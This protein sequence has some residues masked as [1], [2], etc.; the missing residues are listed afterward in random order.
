MPA[1][2]APAF[3]LESL[4]SALPK[5]F[6]QAQS[7]AANH[8]KNFVA[9]C[10]LQSDAAKL[11][12][13]VQ[14]GRSIKLSGERVF[15]EV[16]L[17]MLTRVLP[18]KKGTSVA[19]RIVK[20]TSGYAR[21]ITEKNAEERKKEEADD[22]DDTP[23]SRFLSRIINFLLK[24]CVAKDKVVRFRVVQ[25]I[26]DMI[27]HLGE[28][29]E[30][31]Y[32]SLRSSL[33]ERL[34]DKEAMV[35]VHAVVALSKLSFSEEPS[36]LEEGESSILDTLIDTMTYDTSPDVR[37]A[38]LL[39][40]R[41]VP[42]TLSA[43]LARTRD[44][45]P[46]IRRLV[47]SA[48]L[49]DKCTEGDGERMG[50]T[51]PR[52][53]TIAQ[54]ELIVRNGLGDRE[55]AVRAAA[56]RLLGTWVDVAR[57]APDEAKEEGEKEQDVLADV[58]A[59]LRLFDLAAEGTIPED[60]LLEVF[61]TRVNVF[62]GLVF[63]DEY[64]A[65][66]T[67]ERAF[68]ARVFVEHCVTLN[69]EG[70]LEAALPVVTALAF[71]IQEAYNELVEKMEEQ[72]EEA[73]LRE[74][75]VMDEED[76]EERARKEDERLDK[77]F[78][79]GEILKLAVNLDYADEIGRRK[80]F[81]LVRGMISQDVLPE[82]LLARCLDVLRK[83]S[84]NE[85]DLIRVVV[86]VVHELR[87]PE[88]EEESRNINDGVTDVS[89]TPM[90][91]RTVRAL[92][93]PTAEMTPEEKAHA[94]EVDLRCLSLCIG[95]LERVNGTFEEN[96][97]LEGILGEL[98][99]PAVKRREMMLRERGLISLGLCCLIARRMALNSF[100]LFLGQIQSAPELLKLRV[101]QIVF[102]ILMVHEGAF[103]GPGS[104]NGDRIIEFLLHLLEN[105]ESDKVQALLCVGISKLMLSGMINDERVLKSLVLVFI[106]P[107]TASN[108]ELR[109]CLSYF[110]PI[111]CYSSAANQRRMQ[112]IFVPLYEHLTKVY[113]ECEGDDDMITPPQVGLMFVDWTDP[114]RA[115]AAAK[116]LRGD[117]AENT[118]HFD[119]A[120]DV[121]KALLSSDLDKDDK[122]ALCQLLGK[123]Y[124]PDVVD[125]DKIRT[126]K[127]LMHNLQ[128]RRPLR[129]TVAKNA[130][131][132]FD[133]AISKKFEKQLADFS[134]EE[135]RK[136]E[137]LKELFDYLDEIVPEDDEDEEA[138][139]RGS[140]KRRS[141]SVVTE[142]ST[143]ASVRSSVPPSP[144][145]KKN[146][147]LRLSQSEDESEDDD[148][149]EASRTPPASVAPTRVMPRR[150][151]GEKSK[152]AVA[153]AYSP[154]ETGRS[155]A[156]PSKATQE[157][158]L[159]EDIDNLL[160]GNTTLDSIMDSSEDEEEDE[161]DDIL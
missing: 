74:G 18:V 80:M 154:V 151:A 19:D 114:Q 20:F 142:S 69:D 158:I 23:A 40:L 56:G 138:P 25:C 36:E 106:S 39:N 54:R 55:E 115:A 47:Y 90:T 43:F 42:L 66:L 57:A 32:T 101:L 132:K 116:G 128:S 89:E 4:K 70:R 120:S 5:I 109:Q 38:A 16:Y 99:I 126:L 160:D 113:R 62:D 146:K 28:I 79:I 150:S 3:D 145:A 122:K 88:P 11:T 17:D 140:R 76:E 14:N 157:A 45:D 131:N 82:N 134:E 53:L 100:Q 105:E 118:I 52:A 35:R 121:V 123:L 161:V 107:E 7:T 86:E 84:P 141:A 111:Y 83:L 60:A 130:F 58:I 31:L 65:G 26:A 85:R 49:E 119:F 78:V 144:K 6:D 153:R 71:R 61:K 108:Q 125:D 50:C 67:P 8:Q 110:F 48:V 63:G 81:Q 27:S 156:V 13:S 30:D 133:N 9:L 72:E 94:D 44:V 64:W 117:A 2:T 12:E 59:F 129:D 159:D 149:T 33:M 87:D 1:R 21:F 29:D 137:H 148:R 139:K 15:Q 127:L 152:R 93:K 37:R 136:L 96:S 124:I 22:E 112:Q 135:Y 41:P 98:I 24:G 77:E 75:M 155:S 10:K 51:H 73:M 104:P 92:P 143:A 103:L 97:T 91:V 95:M 68:L 147:R 102:D 46:T 34:R